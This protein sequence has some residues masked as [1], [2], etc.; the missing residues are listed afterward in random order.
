MTPK[1]ELISER[2]M[3]RTK[4][5][6]RPCASKR[7][8]GAV[9]SRGLAKR[10][11]GYAQAL[12]QS[13]F[14]VLVL[15][16]VL[17]GSG[18]AFLPTSRK[19]LHRRRAQALRLSAV[20]SISIFISGLLSWQTIIVAAGLMSPKASPRIGKTMSTKAASVMK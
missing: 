19:L 8:R 6:Q 7:T 2:I 16:S 17:P 13:N 12:V 20:T 14:A 5:L 9:V 11:A 4:I 3:R 1:S 18:G 15:P 10:Q